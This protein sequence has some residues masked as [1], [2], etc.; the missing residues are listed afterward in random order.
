M[1]QMVWSSLNQFRIEAYKTIYHKTLQ[2][3]YVALLMTRVTELCH[4]ASELIVLNRISSVPIIMRSAVESYIDLMC[5]IV[6]ANHIAEMNRSFDHYLSKISGKSSK[7]NELKIWEKFKLAG[8]SEIYNNLYAYLCRSAHGNIET[9][10]RDHTTEDKISIGHSPNK[11]Y[12]VLYLNQIIA[13]ASTSLIEG[14]SFLGFKEEQ[15]SCIREIQH[16]SGQGKYA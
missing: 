15:L 5:I 8:E 4:D 6:D 3:K 1:T 12:L 13:L 2:E 10:V 9:L 14:L 7:K 11:E 16:I